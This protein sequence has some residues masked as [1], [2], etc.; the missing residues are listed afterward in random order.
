MIA[1]LIIAARINVALACAGNSYMLLD[2]N[3]DYTKNC[4]VVVSFD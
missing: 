1:L 2:K 3:H 4:Q